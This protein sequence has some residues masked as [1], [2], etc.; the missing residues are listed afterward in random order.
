MSCISFYM[1][2]SVKQSRLL[3]AVFVTHQTWNRA[4]PT[5]A[6]AAAAAAESA[7]GA[8]LHSLGCSVAD[9]RTGQILSCS[10]KHWKA[11]P[12]AE[13]ISGKHHDAAVRV[14]HAEHLVLDI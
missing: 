4:T 12:G 14:T 9:L 8:A 5:A 2:M 6:A 10:P 1:K 13:R 11:L 7:C 3:S